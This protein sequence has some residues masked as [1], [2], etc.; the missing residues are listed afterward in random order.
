MEG[1]SKGDGLT[2]E[3]C[4]VLAIAQMERRRDR[5]LLPSLKAAA[6]GEILFLRG[7]QEKVQRLITK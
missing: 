6:E 5:D 4:I 2:L 1:F 3:R 7:L